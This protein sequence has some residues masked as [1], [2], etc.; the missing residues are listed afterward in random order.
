[1]KN[2]AL[3]TQESDQEAAVTE[4]LQILRVWRWG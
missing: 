3:Q 2:V 1:M 4:K